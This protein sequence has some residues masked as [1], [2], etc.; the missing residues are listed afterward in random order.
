MESVQQTTTTTTSSSGGSW[1][2]TIIIFI[3][4]ILIVGI[5]AFILISYSGQIWNLIDNLTGTTLTDQ[6]QND[7]QTWA[8]YIYY[9][10]IILI[11]FIF[12]FFIFYLIYA[13]AFSSTSTP[14]TTVISKPAETI[15]TTNVAIQETKNVKVPIS[16]P[17]STAPQTAVATT[18]LP[19]PTLV[20][21]V[22]TTT[23]AP[24][25]QLSPVYNNVQ[26][27]RGSDGQI[28]TYQ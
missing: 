20:P 11:I 27:F 24:A 18:V 12:I 15:P 5:I 14:T 2:W 25:Q 23:V 9:A 1:I 4:I 21:A 7:I 28:Y 16:V 10:G 19:Q 22:A 8:N 13:I 3:I 26:Y 17:I 6:Q